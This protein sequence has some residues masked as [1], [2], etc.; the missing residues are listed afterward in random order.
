M[1]E[2]RSVLAHLRLGKQPGQATLYLRALLAASR[3]RRRSSSSSY[4]SS[5]PLLSGAGAMQRVATVRPQ[6]ALQLP[7]SGSPQSLGSSTQLA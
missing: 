3:R 6:P 1:A 4:R 7:C 2:K 5:A